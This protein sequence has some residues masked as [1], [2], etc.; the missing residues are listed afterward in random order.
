MRS[1]PVCL[2][3]AL[4]ATLGACAAQSS[5]RTGAGSTVDDAAAADILE[6]H[7]HHHHGGA[8]MLIAMSLDSLGL[9]PDQQARVEKLRGE[10]IA[11][12]RPAGVAQQAVVSVLAEG[13]AASAIDRGKLDAAIAQLAA[14]AAAV[15]DSA[16]D[17]LNQLHGVLTPPQRAALVD[18]LEAH[19]ELWR[20]ANQGR[21]DHLAAM[22][23]ELA[24]TPDQVDKVRKEL[25][26]AASP[27]REHDIEAHLRDFEKAFQGDVFDAKTLTRANDTNR[28]MAEWGAG[29]LAR[30]CEAVNPLLT[31]EQRVK[32]VAL[33]REHLS[34]DEGR[35]K[36]GP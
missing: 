25:A 1:R 35:A 2:A 23:A 17:E 22:T 7:R 20:Q 30:F 6:H 18:K 10:L 13:V 21:H 27:L 8:L 3:M 24:L 29:R 31:G 34:H 9:P 33:L 11:K 5:T 28:H 14:A 32:L 26:T 16:V 15:H 36:E 12:M 4:V 19:R